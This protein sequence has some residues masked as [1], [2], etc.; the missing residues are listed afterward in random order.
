MS[1]RIKLFMAIVG[2]VILGSYSLW[3]DNPDTDRSAANY[4]NKNAGD[5]E[6][7]KDG[8]NRA[9][10]SVDSGVHTGIAKVKKGTPKAKK[11]ANKALDKVDDT[12]HGR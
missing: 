9:L 1:K 10:N 5:V 2:V 6:H 8:A 12:V 3:A 11:K 4:D 7:A